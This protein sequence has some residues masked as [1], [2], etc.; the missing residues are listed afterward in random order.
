MEGYLAPASAILFTVCIPPVCNMARFNIF[1]PSQREISFS[2]LGPQT[3]APKKKGCD[4][5]K[6]MS[7]TVGHTFSHLSFRYDMSML[8]ELKCFDDSLHV[9]CK[10]VVAVSNAEANLLLSQFCKSNYF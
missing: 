9:T 3:R 8:L 4:L 7:L 1:A 5:K 10:T 6:I 2:V